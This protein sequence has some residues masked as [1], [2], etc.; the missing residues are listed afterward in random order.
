M[1]LILLAHTFGQAAGGDIGL[2]IFFVLSGFL[3]TFLLLKEEEATGTVSFRDFYARRALRLLPALILALV[4]V[5]LLPNVY[6]QPIDGLSSS[7]LA[8][9]P[10]TLFYGASIALAA[11]Y[12]MGYLDHTWSLSVEEQFYFLWPAAALFLVRRGRFLKGVAGL[13]AFFVVVRVL[14]YLVIGVRSDN[15]LTAQADQFLLGAGLA[16]LATKREIP[17]RLA[18][19]GAAWLALGVLAVLTVWGSKTH[20]G[21]E[22]TFGLLG[23]LTLCGLA[24]SVIVAHLLAPGDGPLQRIFSWT[25]AVWIGRLSYGIY[26]FHFPIFQYVQHQRMALAPTVL[27]EYGVLVPVVLGSWFVVERPALRRKERFSPLARPPTV[28]QPAP[29]RPTLTPDRSEL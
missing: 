23:G 4:I 12:P 22:G 29:D 14:L 6:T 3:I 27:V 24:T 17:R 21:V 11:N 19:S 13:I 26:L 2:N 8:T 28:A 10:I 15:L 7:R 16:W 18:S 20:Q 25:P 1:V 5:A 9:I